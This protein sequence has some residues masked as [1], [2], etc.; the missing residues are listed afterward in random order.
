MRKGC[1]Q[2][3]CSFIFFL[4]G[5]LLCL[6]AGSRQSFSEYRDSLFHESSCCQ[7]FLNR[8]G[9]FR[10]ALTAMNYVFIMY[11]KYISIQ[12]LLVIQSSLTFQFP[13][14]TYSH[15]LRKL[16]AMIYYFPGYYGISN[17]KQEL[18]VIPFSNVFPFSII[19][20]QLQSRIL[21][22]LLCFCR[23]GIVVKRYHSY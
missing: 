21:S 9:I 7:S 2:N 19:K 6:I 16:L 17:L 12:D 20:E 22:N 13:R 3:S 18:E 23:T 15:Y 1:D 11:L 10:E 14:S 8:Y 4:P 5:K